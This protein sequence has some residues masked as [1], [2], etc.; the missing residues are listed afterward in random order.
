MVIGN[1]GF[2]WAMTKK[3]SNKFA[4]P[5]GPVKIYPPSWLDTLYITQRGMCELFYRSILQKS[6]V[7]T[8]YNTSFI[9]CHNLFL[10]NPFYSPSRP[11]DHETV[12]SIINWTEQ[13]NLYALLDM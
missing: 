12:F 6:K 10:Y 2:S 11:A 1:L 9:L 4:P 5:L 13:N 8:Y 3:S 7:Q